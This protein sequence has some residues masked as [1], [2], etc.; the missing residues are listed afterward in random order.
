[1][2]FII[3]RNKKEI[4]GSS[5]E[6]QTG[7]SRVFIDFG[8]PLVTNSGKAINAILIPHSH[9][10][11][12]GFLEH[13]NQDI[14]I[15]MS[16][17][18]KE[19]INVTNIFVT[20]KSNK[21]NVLLIKHMR[22]FQIGDFKITPYLVDHTAFDALAFLVEA[23]GK[24]I[25]YS[26][27]FRGHS[28]KSLLFEKIL[29]DPPKDID[30]LFMEGSII[31]R[32]D[33]VYR[34]E[35]AVQSRI[36]KILRENENIT[37]LFTSPQNVDRLVSAYKACLRTD[38]IFV[39]DIYA[40]FAL[41][42]IRKASK[43]IPRFIWKNIKIKFI[44][45]QADL[46]ADAGYTNLLYAYSKQKIDMFDINR[47]K[48]KILMLGRDDSVFTG[49]LK[50]IDGLSGAKLIYSMREGRLGEKFK[51]YCKQRGIEIESVHT[52]EHATAEDLKAFAKAL[53]PKKLVPIH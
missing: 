49:I 29:K 41:D 33:C 37:F 51:G 53:N 40:A 5:V 10:G 42:M 44:K 23:E 21:A 39:I 16:K 13:V 26:G 4:G 36:E 3:H 19:L 30:T 6:L 31:E 28:R 9:L 27:D 1:M 22:P 38:S 35:K 45:Y 24:K 52:S 15:Y 11:Y 34:D 7:N 14:P 12:Y 43:N 20:K 32:K 25:F 17:G 2:K 48:K 50:D 8:S 46:L 47:K 18:A